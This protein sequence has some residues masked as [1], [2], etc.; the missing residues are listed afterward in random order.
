MGKTISVYRK[1]HFNAAHRLYVRDWEFERNKEVFGLC[2]NPYYHGHNYEIEVCI[3]GSIDPVTGM[4]IN[5]DYLKRIIK[6][7]IEDYFDHKNLNEQ[8]EEFKTLNPTVENICIVSYERLRKKLDPKYRL[9]VRL[10]ETARNY[11]EYGE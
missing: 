6:E 9:R 2:N 7:E 4:L 11:A 3:S 1:G 5:L 10:Y 8:V